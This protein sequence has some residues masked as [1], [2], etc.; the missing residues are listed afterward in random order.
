MKWWN[1]LWLN[2]GFATFMEYI[3]ADRI[4]P[5][6]RLPEQFVSDALLLALHED[7]LVN[8]HPILVAVDDPAEIN[9]IF[10]A[11]SYSKVAFHIFL[12]PLPSSFA[13]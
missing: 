12:L 6:W 9:E 11:I 7:S 13:S 4:N 5:E 8:S 10:D 2:E 3:G 1:D